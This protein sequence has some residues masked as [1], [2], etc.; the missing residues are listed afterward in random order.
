MVV[1]PLL[2]A[3]MNTLMPKMLRLVEAR[4]SLR[5][6]V[7]EDIKSLMRELEMMWS[8]VKEYSKSAQSKDLG[9]VQAT[10]IKQVSELAHKIEDCVDHYI[11]DQSAHNTETPNPDKFAAQIKTF[12]RESDEI[13]VLRDKYKVDTGVADNK[14]SSE[15]ESSSSRS[16]PPVHPFELVGAEAPLRELLE[17]VEEEDEDQTKKLKVISIHGFDGLGKTALPTKVYN[18]K[19]VAKQFGKNRAWVNAAGKDPRQ[20]LQEILQQL[21]VQPRDTTNAEQLCKNLRAYLHDKR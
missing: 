6:D 8:A 16:G 1:P 21:P 3:A 12:R 2:T 20:V 5:H 14:I 11:Y 9:H 13:S 7:Q 17:L 10:W 19:D 15:G 18:H 4:S